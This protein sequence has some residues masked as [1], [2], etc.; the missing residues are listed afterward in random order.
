MKV[1]FGD[2]NLGQNIKASTKKNEIDLKIILNR[3]IAY[4]F[5]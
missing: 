5:P 4:N 2:F 1:L 3:F